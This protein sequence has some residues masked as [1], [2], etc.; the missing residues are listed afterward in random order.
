LSKIT[1]HEWG[2]GFAIDLAIGI[3]RMEIEQRYEKRHRKLRGRAILGQFQ[4]V[5]FEPVVKIGLG[6][7]VATGEGFEC[8]AQIHPPARSS[9]DVIEPLSRI[10]TQAPKSLKS[11]RP[12]RIVVQFGN[13]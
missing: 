6:R 11:E 2:N 13:D 7:V 5:F 4:S 1:T 3:R 9:T 12:E 8:S 10:A